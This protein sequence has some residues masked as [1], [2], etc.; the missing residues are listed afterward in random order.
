MT[1]TVF[2]Y[3]HYNYLFAFTLG[4]AMGSRAASDRPYDGGNLWGA[5]QLLICH[6]IGGGYGRS[7][8]SD[9]PYDW[10]RLWEECGL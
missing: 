8:A 1:I 4:T 10:G 6:M 9:L 5:G 2:K 3:T 7:V